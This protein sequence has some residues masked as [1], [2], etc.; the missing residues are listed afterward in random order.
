[1]IRKRWNQK[2]SVHAKRRMSELR[3]RQL[4]YRKSAA[5][6]QWGM[7]TGRDPKEWWDAAQAAGIT[8]AHSQLERIQWLERIAAP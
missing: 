3:D 5:I 6:T 1:M 4:H 8:R 2:G 7:A